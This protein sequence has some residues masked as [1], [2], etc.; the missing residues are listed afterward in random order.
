[1]GEQGQ[2]GLRCKGKRGG[3]WERGESETGEIGKLGGKG[4][5]ESMRVTELQR[6]TEERFVRGG[7]EG[8]KKVYVPV[9][10]RAGEKSRGPSSRHGRVMISSEN[11]LRQRRQLCP[12]LRV[13]GA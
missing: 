1:M 11:F 10:G 9:F 8:R 4:A 7:E 2:A 3:G 13:G 12:L 5:R 6:V